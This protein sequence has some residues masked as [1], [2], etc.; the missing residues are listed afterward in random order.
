MDGCTVASVFFQE[1]DLGLW[2]WSAGAGVSCLDS[3]RS[4]YKGHLITSKQKQNKT[5][6]WFFGK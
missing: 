1:I 4:S 2:T 6:K 5:K 3:L